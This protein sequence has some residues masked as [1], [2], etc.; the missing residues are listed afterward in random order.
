MAL[1]LSG[2]PTTAAAAGA[3]AA[4][5]RHSQLVR[6]YFEDTDAGG[7]V[8][9]ASWLRFFER[10]RTDWL[11]SLGVSQAELARTQGLGFVVRDLRIEYLRPARLD[12]LLRIEL[13]LCE[14][15]RASLTLSQRACLAEADAGPTLV[16]AQ[17]RIAVI[18]Q[19]SGRAVGLP[20]DLIARIGPPSGHTEEFR[21]H[22]K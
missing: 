21:V 10:C 6:V 12:D 11:R 22:A 8:Y 18:E 5:A 16:S 2:S 4:G 17:V 13:D 14:L 9:H 1:A 19:Q 7:I 15:R 3:R 20:A